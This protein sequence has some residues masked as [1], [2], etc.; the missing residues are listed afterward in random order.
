MRTFGTTFSALLVIASVASLDAMELLEDYQRTL[1]DLCVSSSLLPAFDDDEE[2]HGSNIDFKQL[3]AFVSP[4][5]PT[6]TINPLNIHLQSPEQNQARKRPLQESTK[7]DESSS[8]SAS[9]FSVE[10]SASDSEGCVSYQSISSKSRK[11]ESQSSSSSFSKIV[12]KVEPRD[13]YES[14]LE[15]GPQLVEKSKYDHVMHMCAF[16]GCSKVFESQRD[17]TQH[18]EAHLNGTP[19]GCIRS[20]CQQSF[21]KII[22]WVH[23][24]HGHMGTLAS[25][26]ILRAPL[27][28]LF[29]PEDYALS[30][31]EIDT[32]PFDCISPG[33]TISTATVVEWI[34]HH[35]NSH[36]PQGHTCLQ[37][38]CGGVFSS[39]GELTYHMRSHAKLKPYV[40]TH[41]G[42]DQKFSR[43]LDLNNHENVHFLYKFVCST[44]GCKRAFTRFCGFK[45]HQETCKIQI[46]AGLQEEFE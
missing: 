13:S 37:K 24:M 25:K 20:G 29:H 10:S 22:D 36:K 35:Q 27:V 45:R 31:Q 33:C 11:T 42:C 40:C 19:Y 15:F 18:I 12:V 32:L 30:R 44:P 14:V 1:D 46:K 9:S 3:H 16:A 26:K 8:S 28:S 2:G 17:F 7:I 21:E 6:S 5:A 23:H 4:K 39:A 41:E 43:L 34:K 38:A